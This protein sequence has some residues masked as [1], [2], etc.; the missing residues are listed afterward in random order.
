[1]IKVSNKDFCIYPSSLTGKFVFP[2]FCF[3]LSNL[4]FDT[5]LLL[6]IIKYSFNIF[7]RQNTIKSSIVLDHKL[8]GPWDSLIE[9]TIYTRK[10]IQSE[11][12]TNIEGNLSKFSFQGYYSD[13]NTKF[14]FC[15]L[16]LCNLTKEKDL[17]SQ[18]TFPSQE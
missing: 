3:F 6:F 2:L 14:V 15:E 1:M 5:R 10:K 17:F 18:S 16:I 12:S 13:N 11:M 9:W 7:E 8:Y 4:S